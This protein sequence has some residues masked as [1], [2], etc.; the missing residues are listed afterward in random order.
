[1]HV[2]LD[3]LGKLADVE[4]TVAVFVISLENLA[5]KEHQFL[6]EVGWLL[7]VRDLLA[8]FGVAADFIFKEDGIGL[9]QK[10]W[11]GWGNPLLCVLALLLRLKHGIESQHVGPLLF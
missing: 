6:V 11:F 10:I 5:D 3:E 2:F 4:A 9:R 7:L 1:M 8:A